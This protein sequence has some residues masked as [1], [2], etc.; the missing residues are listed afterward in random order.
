[1]TSTPQQTNATGPA[2]TKSAPPPA[3]QAPN[4]STA[5]APSFSAAAPASGR[6]S[7]ASA[8]KGAFPPNVSEPSNMSVTAGGRPPADT[9]S[10]VNGRN[11]TIPAVPSVGGP[12]IVNGNN[13]D[14]ARK[15]SF[16]V[17]SSSA[18]NFAT[19]GGAVGGVQNKANNIQFGSMNAGGSP[20]LNN[21]P[22]LASQSPSNLG[23]A[24]ANPRIVSPQNSPSP[25]PQ[26][27]ASGGRPPSGLQG[28]NNEVR[29]G[30]MGVDSNDT[31]VRFQH[32]PSKLFANESP[33]AT[34]PCY[35]SRPDGTGPSAPSRS[36]R[37][38]SI[39]T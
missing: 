14:H 37:F 2:D 38:L 13:V 19:N 6:S 7:Y 9:I 28:Q 21:P 1:M 36:S 33:T 27:A 34:A 30:Q 39:F 22:A 8:T 11:P 20:A 35:A 3:V 17:T 4:F 18:T 25:I 16:T 26:L 29:F 10:P 15:P 12:T 23:V 31:N 5:S 32:T 24:H